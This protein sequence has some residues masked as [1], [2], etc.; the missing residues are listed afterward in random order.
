TPRPG[1]LLF[2]AEHGNIASA[3]VRGMGFAE[4]FGTPSGP[5]AWTPPVF[6]CVLAVVFF[7]FGIKTVAALHALLLL[8][9]LFAATT[10][11]FFLCA[12]EFA[13]R[14]VER[15]YFTPVFGALVVVHQLALGP[16]L[17]TAWFVAMLNAAL[18]AAAL[19]VW[20]AR[21]AGW[22]W[23]LVAVC[24]LL[25]LTHAGSGL[26]AGAVVLLL[27]VRAARRD[28]WTAV[29]PLVAPAL[30][31]VLAV[32]G[33]TARNYAVFGQLIPLKAA[34]AFEIWLAEEC[35]T[36]GV[37]TDATMLAH[38]PLCSAPALAD[39]TAR[40]ERVYLAD[41]APRALAVREAGL[42]RWLRHV[43]ARARNVFLHCDTTPRALGFNRPP[44]PADAARLVAA[45]LAVRSGGSLNWTSLDLAPAEFGRRAAAARLENLDAVAA[46]WL[47]AR[48]Y[49][50]RQGA[51]PA[52]V[53]SAWLFGAVPLVALLLALALRRDSP[54][55]RLGGLI[56]LVALLPNVLVTHY[57]AHQL[58]F[59]GLHAL[60]LV[61]AGAAFY[62]RT[63]ARRALVAIEAHRFG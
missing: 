54:E 32:G 31:G 48:A 13:G 49:A 51:R 20:H 60:F 59:L 30:A 43:A 56:Y 3:L 61:S 19:G 23:L 40:G 58:H 10:V 18:L 25:P 47:G 63:R 62:E 7:V 55:L 27:G 2:V 16:W 34:G 28:G 52:A 6:P 1:H 37:I 44:S 42:G 29:R 53:A 46:E 4:A 57:L 8:D 35:T 33:W 21:G 15:K 41:F 26:A 24:A 39:Y 22:R 36:D 38:H 14:A 45:G 12:L 11:F 17:T 9:A 5:T 50:E